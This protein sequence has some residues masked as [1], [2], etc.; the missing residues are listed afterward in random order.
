MSTGSTKLDGTAELKDGAWVSI[1]EVDRVY[2][3]AMQEHKVLVSAK[4][5]LQTELNKLEDNLARFKH[6]G[7]ACATKQVETLKIKIELADFLTSLRDQIAVGDALETNS[8]E[9]D[10]EAACKNFLAFKKAAL[11]HKENVAAKNRSYKQLQ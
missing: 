10:L 11:A 1:E 6:L 4:T 3:A 7:P 5:S 9:A 2:R 8:P